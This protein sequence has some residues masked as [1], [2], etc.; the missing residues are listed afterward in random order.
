LKKYIKELER[1]IKTH[2]GE[3]TH[4]KNDIR[5]TRVNE[6]ERENKTYHQEIIH[7]QR[8][9]DNELTLIEGSESFQKL[10]LNIAEAEQ[11]LRDAKLKINALEG[12]AEQ[13]YFI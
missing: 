7:L 6:L 8:M 9:I 3:I 4:L 12:T 1:T 5:Y 10:K 11:N 13:L 2:S